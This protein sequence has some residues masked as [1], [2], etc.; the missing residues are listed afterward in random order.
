MGQRVARITHNG[1]G[2]TTRPLEMTGCQSWDL[3]V[4]GTGVSDLYDVSWEEGK[5]LMSV[6]LRDREV[7][8]SKCAE[9]KFRPRN[10]VLDMDKWQWGF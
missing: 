9:G 2:Y 8:I 7:R 4:C 5:D 1:M 6:L 3:D 10:F